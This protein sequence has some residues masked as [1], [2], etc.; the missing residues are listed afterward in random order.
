MARALFLI[1]VQHAQFFGDWAIP[2]SKE[3]LGRIGERLLLARQQ[4][5]TVFHVQNDGTDSEPDAPG[6]PFW[7]LV[8]APAKGERVIR[9]TAQNVFE[10]NPYLDAE[11]RHSG[12]T[13]I[14]FAGVQS[15]L[16]LRASALGA[17]ALGYEIV[18]QREL[19]G[20]FDSE[21]LRHS[22]VSDRIQRELIPD[23]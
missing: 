22:D 9:K 15:E 8:F 19:H 13:A 7:Q 14:E 10:D 1:D 16:C 6:M 23:A 12:I 4:G 2:D 5:T 11:L 21:D 17:R 18:L 20:S 3:L